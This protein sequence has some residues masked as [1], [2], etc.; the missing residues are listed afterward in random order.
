MAEV[1]VGEVNDNKIEKNEEKISDEER[2]ECQKVVSEELGR[3]DFVKHITSVGDTVRKSWKKQACVSY[4]I[5]PNGSKILIDHVRKVMS[6]TY[7]FDDDFDISKWDVSKTMG[8]MAKEFF[9]EALFHFHIENHPNKTKTNI[10]NLHPVGFSWISYSTNEEFKKVYWDL[11]NKSCVYMR[12]DEQLD[13]EK[14]NYGRCQK[15]ADDVLKVESSLYEFF[16]NKSGSPN[17]KIMTLDQL[18]SKYSEFDWRYLLENEFDGAKID[19]STE[20]LVADVAYLDMVHKYTKD[21]KDDQ[22][23]NRML[24]NYILSCATYWLMF[25]TSPKYD[26]LYWD[27]IEKVWGEQ[28]EQT[29]TEYCIDLMNHFLPEMSAYFLQGLL[30]Y[31]SEDLRQVAKTLTR[32]RDTFTSH[33]MQSSWADEKTKDN[34]KKRFHDIEIHVGVP[35]KVIKSDAI[36]RAYAKLDIRQDQDLITIL[37]RISELTSSLRGEIYNLGIT[38]FNSKLLYK[39]NI[40]LKGSD[41]YVP[42]PVLQRPFYGKSRPGVINIGYLNA[43]VGQKLASLLRFKDLFFDRRSTPKNLFTKQSMTNFKKKASCIG[44]RY[45]N[46]DLKFPFHDGPNLQ[47]AFANFQ[48][49]RAKED[50]LPGIY[51]NFDQLLY[52]LSVQSNCRKITYEKHLKLL[53]RWG[54]LLPDELSVNIAL[55]TSRHFAKVFQCPA[56]S[57]MNPPWYNRCEL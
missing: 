39:R 26:Q 19:G 27:V 50:T 40:V 55:S 53:F 56:G 13:K 15:Y 6:S 32:F 12:Q 2:A 10:F 24:N 34:I 7:M 17:Q 44:E 57:K 38:N 36:K 11:F 25:H 9:L 8:N 33:I 49:N 46:E 16:I 35:E 43:L 42:L 41:L 21:M 20:I 48:K 37:I 47:L 51:L 45:I 18:S 5:N 3:D 54:L 1:V 23:T 31:K 22:D 30:S 4:E 28:P 14:P 29:Q 52:T